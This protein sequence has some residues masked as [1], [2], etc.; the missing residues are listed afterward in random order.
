MV[1]SDGGVY[2]YEGNFGLVT[3]DH[4]T[5]LASNM[6]KIY[7]I[8]FYESSH[9]SEMY[10]VMASL[11]TIKY[12]LLSLHISLPQGKEFHMYCDNSSVVNKI[13][14]RRKLRRTVNQ[15]HYPDVDI[16]LQLLY[17]LK[18]LE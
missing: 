4:Y 7:S 9:Q 17:E 18:D 14:F 5:I 15:H 6:G 12:L 11:V 10:G 3:A 1:V 13:N 16:E 8:D 2:Q